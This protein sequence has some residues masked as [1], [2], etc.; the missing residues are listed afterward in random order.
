M[1]R[2]S[3]AHPAGRVEAVRPVGRATACA[4]ACA[5]ACVLGREQS[6][7]ERREGSRHLRSSS[8]RSVIQPVAR[9]AAHA[10]TRT[11]THCVLS[12]ARGEERCE[13]CSSAATPRHGPAALGPGRRALSRSL[14]GGRRVI[15]TELCKTVWQSHPASSIPS[16]P[17]PARTETQGAG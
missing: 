3:P 11:R 12:G 4:C 2:P 14:T 16:R 5:C 6:D 8:G 7:R 10:Y 17:I 1:P 13:E 9:Q 15:T